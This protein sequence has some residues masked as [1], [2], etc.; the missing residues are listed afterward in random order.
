LTVRQV[1]PRAGGEI[2]E[3]LRIYVADVRS[4]RFPADEHAYHLSPE[5]AGAFEGP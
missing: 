2:V 4:G 1:T 3:A 5:E